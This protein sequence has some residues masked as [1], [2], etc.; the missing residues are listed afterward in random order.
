[1][2]REWSRGWSRERPDG[3]YDQ[4]VLWEPPAEIRPELEAQLPPD[5]GDTCWVLLGDDE[6]IAVYAARGRGRC[7]TF[8]LQ[9]GAWVREPEEKQFIHVR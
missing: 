2:C 4:G 8:H 9:E 5:R 6:A 3:T 1:V 7:Y